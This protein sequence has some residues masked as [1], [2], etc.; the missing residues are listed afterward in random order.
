MSLTRSNLR[1]TTG[2]MGA[3][4]IATALAT[5]LVE[6][7]Y[8]VVA[9]T[10]RT[11]ESA[12]RLA[13]LLPGAKAFRT[14]QA[15]AHEADLVF[16]TTPDGAIR[17]VAQSVHWRP[18]QTAVHCSGAHSA[19]LLKPAAPNAGVFH[20]L[21]T[22]PNRIPPPTRLRGSYAGIQG[23]PPTI[24]LLEG[25]AY[26][27]GMHPV[28]VPSEY[29]AL[30]HAAAVFVSNYT[31]TLIDVAA[32]LWAPLGVER[33]E[34]LQ[35]LLPLL[36]ATVENLGATGLPH[37]LSG[38]IARGDAETVVRHLQALIKH[39]PEAARLYRELGVHTIP[40][41]QEKGTITLETA[42]KLRRLLP[43]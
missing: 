16:I 27:L 7:G 19:D 29:T 13:A 8:P 15:V 3:G 1:P 34:A 11:Q 39:A 12:R 43:N 17:D 10:S 35:A 22:F 36:R 14:P 23:D 21:Q 24:Q 4:A 37:S 25:L 26:D 31:V 42:D 6:A 5:A 38:P 32:A 41:A 30:Y 20:P 18:T 9:V 28:L 33:N 2:F 40:L